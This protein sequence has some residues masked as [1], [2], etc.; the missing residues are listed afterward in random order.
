MLTALQAAARAEMRARV[1]SLYS[2][3]AAGDGPLGTLV[4]ALSRVVPLL[5]AI[6]AGAVVVGVVLLWTATRPA[7]WVLA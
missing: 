6:A 1:V 4:A 5:S 3:A 7:L 2:L